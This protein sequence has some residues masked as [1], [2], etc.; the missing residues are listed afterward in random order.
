[1]VT[2]AYVASSRNYSLER[3]LIET[4]GLTGCEILYLKE[5]HF[6]KAYNTALKKAQH[7][8]IVFVRHDVEIRNSGWGQKVLDQMERGKYGIVGTVG[9]LIV[10]MSGLVWEKE[11]PLVG[12]I[13]YE[14]FDNKNE[15][16][17]SEVFVGKLIEV[18]TIDDAFFIV[19]RRQ[20][21]KTFNKSYVGDSF[22]ELDFCLENYER[23][24]KIGV[25][26]DV[27]VVKKEFNAHDTSW[28]TNQKLFVKQHKNLPFRLKPHLIVSGGN[29]KP[30]RSPKVTIII[31]SK[32][33]PV[34]L[35]SCLDAIEAKTKYSNY[36]IIIVDLGS[37]PDEIRSIVEY[38]KGRT[39]IR[40]VEKNYEHAP[41]VIEEILE[42]EVDAETELLLFCHP[43]VL[44]LNDAISRMV[45]TYLE[46]PKHCGTLGIRMHNRQNML[47]HFGLQLFSTE[48]DEGFELGLGYQGF[49]S[50]YKYKNK[51]VKNILGS[52]KDF[53]M[54]PYALYKEIG[55]FNKHYLH[56]LED[57]EF[58]IAAI[59]HGRKNMLVGNAVC[60]YLGRDVPRF[61]PEDFT[62]LVNFI[63]QHVD[64]VAP[65]VDL[66]YAA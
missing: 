7:D 2:F 26:F 28:I 37:E 65:Y 41:S 59:L 48:T 43:E 22:Y 57:F 39:H 47:R 8:V 34:E 14:T 33:K 11:E 66:L 52:S 35:A 53:L 58:N 16:R 23:G 9:S 10:P 38:I 49:Q 44:L 36:E 29:V 51:L 54:V 1:M 24:V 13:W 64:S 55:G 17:F 15:N 21:K 60:Y 12:R 56:S 4:S 6:A 40:L 30:E 61:M 18:V 20:V 31:E 19:D 32:G 63:N 62:T 3:N 5:N 42:E 45:K 50:A 25:T 46:D 27:K